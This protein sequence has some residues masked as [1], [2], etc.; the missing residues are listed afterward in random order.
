VRAG[1]ERARSL[2]PRSEDFRLANGLRVFLVEN[3]E[4]PLVSL[5]VRVAGGSVEDPAGRQGAASLLSR[6]LG[7][8]AAGR[9]AAAFHE[10]VDFVGGAFGVS[11]AQRWI[12]VDAEFLSK[13]QDLALELTCDVLMRPR[14]DASEFAKERGVALDALAQAREQPN[15]VLPLYHAQWTFAGNPYARPVSGDEA[16]LAALTLDDV[17]AAAAR[18][19]GPSRTWLAVAG[20]FDPAAMRRKVEARFGAWDAKVADPAPVPRWEPAKEPGVLLVDFPSSLQA[21]FRFGGPGIDWR[22]PD[23]AARTLA[24]SV[25]G[26]QFTSRLN[27]ALRTD[28]GLTY[29]A[30][31]AFDDDAWGAFHVA[32]YTRVATTREAIEMALGVVRK[33]VKDGISQAELD[34]ARRYIQGQFAP[35]TVET[36]DQAASM[37]LAL[38]F[39]GLPRDLVDGYFARLDALKLEDVN[40]VIRAH[41]PSEPFAF[42]VIGPAEKVRDFVGTLGKIT[43]CKLA[44]PG[45]GPKR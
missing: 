6:L 12:R 24:N 26:V 18:T 16:S 27:R 19:L 35:A 43:E 5:E 10:A 32:T 29:G 7:K 14:L 38:E 8:G 11:C 23:Y 15:A 21:Y 2:L 22:H 33:F 40:R 34:S 45:F 4:T 13:D 3:H 36:A 44:D 42:T 25:L 1:E 17:K 37:I 30:G 41:F 28:S 31:S 9:D 20:D 39:D